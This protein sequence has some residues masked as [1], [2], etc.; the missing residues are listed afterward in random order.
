MKNQHEKQE[1]IMDY[2]QQRKNTPYCQVNVLN[3]HFVN[4]YIEKFS[5][6]Y[7]PM[8]YGAHKVP[9]LGKILSNMYRCHLLYRYIVGLQ[10]MESGF[11]KWIY[12]YELRV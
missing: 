6:K 4:E 10:H 5:P 3:S 7:I 8:P 9:E 12:T 2:L 1:F 11:P